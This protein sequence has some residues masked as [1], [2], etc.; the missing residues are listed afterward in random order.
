M[1]FALVILFNLTVK[2]FLFSVKLQVHSLDQF[3]R[4]ELH[5]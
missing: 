4:T 1:I 3:Q 2:I 5:A